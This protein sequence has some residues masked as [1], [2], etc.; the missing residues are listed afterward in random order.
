[1]IEEELIHTLTW[2]GHMGT[3][4]LIFVSWGPPAGLNPQV[5]TVI[6]SLASTTGSFPLFSVLHPQWGLP[7]NHVST[8]TLCTLSSHFRVSFWGGGP[9]Q[10]LK[11]NRGSRAICCFSLYLSF[12]WSLHTVTL[13]CEMVIDS[14]QL[15]IVW[16][17]IFQLYRPGSNHSGETKTLN[18]DLFLEWWYV[19]RCSLVILDSWQWASAPSQSWGV[20]AVNNWYTDFLLTF[21]AVFNTLY[22]VF[23]TIIQ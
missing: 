10:R 13:V 1:M 6:C 9:K 12:I 5:P 20:T 17:Q 11:D 23:N 21:N 7:R 15:V 16:L 22:K 3:T 18:F 8:S 14:P 2:V 4:A 19:V